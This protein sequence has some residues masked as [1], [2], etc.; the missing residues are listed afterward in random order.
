MKRSSTG[1]KAVP[2]SHLSRNSR[3][4]RREQRLSCY[5]LKKTFIIDSD[6]EL[7]MYLIP[8]I[9]IDL[10]ISLV[11]ETRDAF[12]DYEVL[13]GVVLKLFKC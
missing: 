9:R 5:K 8:C 2:K 10:L 4:A 11:G 7:F 3:P 6:S 1:S 13:T 12:R